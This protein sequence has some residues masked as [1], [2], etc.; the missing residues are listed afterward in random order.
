MTPS[1]GSAV[2]TYQTADAPRSVEAGT[3][4]TDDQARRFVAVTHR[5]VV[6]ASE[7]ELA[8]A[9]DS[10]LKSCQS[11]RCEVLTSSINS[12]TASSPPNGELSVRMDPGDFDK[13][14]RVLHSAVAIVEHATEGVD[15]TSDVVD[16]EAKLKNLTEFRDQL[17]F[18]LSKSQAGVK[19][20]IEIERELANVQAQIDSLAM[21]RK[22]LANETEKIA[23]QITFRSKS[24]ATR[25]GVFAPIATALEESVSV[26]SV[27]MAGLITSIFA[28]IPWLVLIIPAI[29]LF[30]RY[31]R[32][33]AR[34]DKASA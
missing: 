25:T 14:L 3:P 28:V 17:R 5:I 12:K 26:L 34:K 23:V 31:R 8:G 15:K 1:N 32:K 30:I 29:W 21:M 10:I 33:K 20:L 18:M 22:A 16:A 2:E 19:D 13:F 11:M 7:S 24:S 6:E 4:Q 27:S 9:W